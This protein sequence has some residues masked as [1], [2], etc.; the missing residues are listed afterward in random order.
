MKTIEWGFLIVN[1]LFL[2]GLSAGLFFVS[3]LAETN[4]PPF[5]LVEA[6][7]ELVAGFMTEYGWGGQVV[8]DATWK[9]FERPYGPSIWGHDRA[10]LTQEDQAKA[11]ALRLKNAADGFRRPVQVMDGN[12]EVMAGVC[13]WWDNLKAKSVA[14]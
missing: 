8:D 1:Y 7:S 5:D 2:G 11:R 10:W 4:R 13:P 6:E 3:A 12:Y 14:Q 9:P